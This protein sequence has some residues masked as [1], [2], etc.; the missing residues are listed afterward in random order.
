MCGNSA[1]DCG[2]WVT[3]ARRIAA[4]E[5]PESLVSPIITVPSDG[6]SSPETTRRTVDLPAPFG[7]T[8]QVMVPPSHRR[9]TPCSTA[10]PP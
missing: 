5:R 4:A 1:C 3:P 9:S 10:P 6:V 2:T 7:P 8:M